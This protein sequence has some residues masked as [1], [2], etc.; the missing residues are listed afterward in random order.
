MTHQL[1]KQLREKA[2]FIQDF[3]SVTLDEEQFYRPT[4]AQEPVCLVADGKDPDTAEP[5]AEKKK[6]KS[7][8]IIS[9][10]NNFKPTDR[11]NNFFLF[12]SEKELERLRDAT[13]W[14]CDG[15]FASKNEYLKKQKNV[16]KFTNFTL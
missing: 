11:K 4:A 7:K 14:A 15:S 2:P 1:L 16:V 6:N 9:N 13:E 3:Y 8:N 12:A 5:A 10:S